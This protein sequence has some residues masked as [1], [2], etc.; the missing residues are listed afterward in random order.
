M[1]A[2]LVEEQFPDLE[3]AQVERVGAGWD[4]IAYRVNGKWMFRFPRRRVAVALIDTECALLPWVAGSLPL[5]VPVPVLVGKPTEEF[6][7]PFA[8]YE[9]LPG[10]TACRANLDEDVRSRAA[11][12]LGTL[13]RALHAIDPVERARR[14]APEDTLART[15]VDGR[16]SRALDRLERATALGLLADKEPLLSYML[17]ITS[18]GPFELRLVHG[19]LYA[20]HL[21][22]DGAGDVT[23]VIDW[24]DLHLGHPAVDLAIA[25]L[26]LP[27]SAHPA[28][29]DA[30]GP[31]DPQVWRLAR[32]REVTGG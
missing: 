26:F 21:L 20:R 10:L 6:P 28:F 22:V 12:R 9:E 18:I 19:D 31:V 29:L 1:A 32:F 11:P 2:E 30:Y 7:W 3:P 25:H 8:G 15:D 16:R 23:G 24:G 5:A 4:N 17:D 27:P 14:G 13:L